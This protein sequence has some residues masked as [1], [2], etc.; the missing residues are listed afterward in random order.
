MFNVSVISFILCIGVFSFDKTQ[1]AILHVESEHGFHIQP[2][3][4]LKVRSSIP[5]AAIDISVPIP[6]RTKGKMRNSSL[7]TSSS[8]ETG[9]VLKSFANIVLLFCKS[10]PP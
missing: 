8:L 7:I 1:C 3:F 10:I 4:N 5:K 2:R 6:R 9:F